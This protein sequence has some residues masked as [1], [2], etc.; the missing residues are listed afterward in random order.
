MI[1][2]PAGL[3]RANAAQARRHRTPALLPDCLGDDPHG[4]DTAVR[5]GKGLVAEV[6]QQVPGGDMRPHRERD[7][8]LRAGEPD[9]HRNPPAVPAVEEDDPVAQAVVVGHEPAA[10]DVLLPRLDDVPRLHHRQRGVHR[11]GCAGAER[12]WPA[13]AP[14]PPPPLSTTPEQGTG[15]GICA[16]FSSRFRPRVPRGFGGYA[17]ESGANPVFVTHRR[18]RFRGPA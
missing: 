12:H 8:A 10:H 11:R 14:A 16:S 6:N 3:A 18:R 17:G 15:S 5:G 4:D 1:P 2:Y 13:P 7:P 9:P